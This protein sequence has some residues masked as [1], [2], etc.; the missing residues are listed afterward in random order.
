MAAGG[1]KPHGSAAGEHDA[2]ANTISYSVKAKLNRPYD[3]NE[4]FVCSSEVTR[5]GIAPE[6]SRV[7]WGKVLFTRATARPP[8]SSISSSQAAP[9][10]IPGERPPL[11]S[12]CLP[13]LELAGARA[14]QKWWLRRPDLLRLKRRRG[15]KMRRVHSRAAGEGGAC[16]YRLNETV[17]H[18]KCLS[19]GPQNV[20]C[21]L[22]SV[23]VQLPVPASQQCMKIRA[24]FRTL[25]PRS[26]SLADVVNRAW[27]WWRPQRIWRL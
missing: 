8:T 12:L 7:R 20:L 26:C 18:G 23:P 6:A 25:M 13:P 21:V 27:I 2:R 11:W 4:W 19:A 9:L 22:H 3:I 5:S 14:P 10:S 17:Q 24:L 16:G 1:T 15:T